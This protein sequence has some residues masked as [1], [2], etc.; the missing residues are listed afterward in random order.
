MGMCLA[1]IAVAWPQPTRLSL[2]AL[3]HPLASQRPV[4][5]VPN[6]Y[7][8]SEPR[9]GPEH[10][11]VLPIT[12]GTRHIELHILDRGSWNEAA[13]TPSFDVGWEGYGT[14]APVEDCYLVRETVAAYIR[15][16]DPGGLRVGNL[17][18]HAELPTLLERV[19]DSIRGPRGYVAGALLVGISATLAALPFGPLALGVLLA[20]LS[21][22][23]RATRLDLPF[24]IDGEVQRLFT[25]HLPLIEMLR[26]S[27]FEERHPPLMFILL[28]MVQTFGQ[29]E[30]IV[31]LPAVVAGTLTGPAIL[32]MAH[33]LRSDGPGGR[34]VTSSIAA[35]CAALVAVASPEL[36]VRSRE[37]SELAVFGLISVLTLGAA[38]RACR[39]PTPVALLVVGI[40]HALLLW[41]YYLA[42]FLLVGFWST[43]WW[44]G[45]GSRRPMLAAALGSVL[46]LPGP[47]FAALAWV[48][49]LPGRQAAAR[50][51]EL[52]W[53]EQPPSQIA[54]E[55]GWIV[56]HGLSVPFVVLVVLL[57]LR[58][59]VRR[60]WGAVAPL[61]GAAAV[62]A[63][64]VALVP[65]A[66]I[67]AY[68]FVCVLPLFPLALALCEL[69]ATGFSRIFAAVAISAVTAATVP[70]GLTR[71]AD[72]IYTANPSASGRRYARLINSRPESHVAVL[73]PW[74]CRLVAYNLALEAGIEIDWR[75]L[76]KQGGEITIEGLRQRFVAMSERPTYEAAAAPMVASFDALSQRGDFIALVPL[77][78]HMK[79]VDD[80][81]RR[82]AVLDRTPVDRLLLCPRAGEHRGQS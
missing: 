55:I 21:F 9:P 50:F 1:L 23:I 7:I 30:A 75:D 6:D 17:A 13:H 58:S 22:W 28:H 48:R 35:A 31:R 34:P 5:G 36:I 78:L 39:H 12:S 60:E 49:D 33:W 73:F 32:A 71:D 16:N 70:H 18:R 26:L 27:A 3:L 20:G 61:V 52:M 80:W 40:G 56:L 45:R 74:D 76:R 25:G 11:I 51:P 53:G 44:I 41:T 4:P 79:E 72:R 24:H 46:G 54:S 69:P 43:M 29:S 63:A 15:A 62:A 64:M 77:P 38:V 65:S 2:D 8:L 10:D 68:Y 59:L 81:L 19:L 67:Q 42:P 47:I 14:N 37:V 57:A 82:C 66:R